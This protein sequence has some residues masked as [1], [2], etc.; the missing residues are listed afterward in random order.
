M[1]PRE[2][3]FRVRCEGGDAGG[4]AE[5]IQPGDRIVF[6]VTGVQAFGGIVRVTSEMYE[7]RT[8]IWPGN[9]PTLLRAF[10]PKNTLPMTTRRR[11]LPQGHKGFYRR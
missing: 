10:P 7:D 4:M 6:Y 3:G 5:Q 9:S 2:H 11:S 1:P 8:K